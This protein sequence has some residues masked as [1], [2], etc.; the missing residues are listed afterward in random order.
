ML[1]KEVS[2]EELKAILSSFKRDK[3]LRLDEMPI[4]FYL[5]FYDLLEEGLLRVIE[6][7]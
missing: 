5:G 6:E 4:E 7:A 3:S 1:K 2:K